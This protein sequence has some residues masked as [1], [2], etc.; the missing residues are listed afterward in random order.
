MNIL[1]RHKLVLLGD[2]DL[3]TYLY[4]FLIQKKVSEKGYMNVEQ[5]RSREESCRICLQKKFGLKIS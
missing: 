1:N 4:D 5:L 2:T 3:C